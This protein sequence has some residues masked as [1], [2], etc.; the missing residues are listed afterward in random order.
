MKAHQIYNIQTPEFHRIA[1]EITSVE[2]DFSK[3][4]SGKA[5]C[6]KNCIYGREY[7]F[8]T[9]RLHRELELKHFDPIGED[10]KLFYSHR[11]KEKK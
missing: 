8:W 4:E 9:C 2:W 7:G 1:K 3:L 6:V 11:G 10:G 5:C